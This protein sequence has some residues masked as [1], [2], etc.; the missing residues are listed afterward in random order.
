MSIRR[1]ATTSAYYRA[2]VRHLAIDIGGSKTAFAVVSEG[3][4]TNYTAWPS[5]SNASESLDRI[6][7]RCLPMIDGIAACGVAFG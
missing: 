7:S 4:I 6:I 2:C 1:P 3:A 5:P